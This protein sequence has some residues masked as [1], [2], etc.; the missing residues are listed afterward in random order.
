M[1]VVSKL[2]PRDMAYSSSGHTVKLNVGVM[3]GHWDVGGNGHVA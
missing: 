3:S 1:W 2:A